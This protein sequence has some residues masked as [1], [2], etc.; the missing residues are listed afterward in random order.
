MPRRAGKREV[1]TRP[2][3]LEQRPDGVAQVGA[4]QPRVHVH[5]VQRVV[6]AFLQPKCCTGGG[7]GGACRAQ[8]GARVRAGAQ[9]RL[10]RHGGQ[11][12]QAGATERLQ[13]QGLCLVIR[14][15][16]GQHPSAGRQPGSQGAITM[17]TRD[18]LDALARGRRDIQAQYFANHPCSRSSG[19][20]G[21]FQ[22]GRSGRQAV[23]AMHRA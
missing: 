1:R 14:V 6:H 20:G 2:T 22:C 10:P 21:G 23:V 16:G 15:V 19:Q 4:V 11:P 5:R 12:F 9:H 18:G 8:Q 7:E 3:R 13:Q 17:Q